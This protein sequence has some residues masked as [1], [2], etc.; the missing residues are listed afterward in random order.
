[1]LKSMKARL[2]ASVAML[3]SRQL[4]H[5]LIRA[6]TRILFR[7]VQPASFAAR[8]LGCACLGRNQLLDNCPFH[9]SMARSLCRG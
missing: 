9:G 3:G 2:L 5:D 1:M 4:E 8:A 7:L 6:M